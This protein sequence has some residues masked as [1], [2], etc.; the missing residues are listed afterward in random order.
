MCDFAF[1][2]DVYCEDE[3]RTATKL[4]S[5]DEASLSECEVLAA[6]RHV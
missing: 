6:S 5:H 3:A 4:L 1:S 2:R